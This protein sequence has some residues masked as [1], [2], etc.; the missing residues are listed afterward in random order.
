M[1]PWKSSILLGVLW[2][3]WHLPLFLGLS[4]T[5]SSLPH[6]ILILT[7]FSIVMTFL[8][9]AS[10]QSELVAVCGHAMFNTT[11]RWFTA[12]CGDAPL[13]ENLNPE[14]VIGLC[15]VIAGVLL[16]LFTKGRLA[17]AAADSEA[18]RADQSI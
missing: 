17:L 13:R 1:P 9:N 15:G 18:G 6:F 2:A 3:C 7:G 16:I 4:W 5:S 8:F 11:S 14:L 10:G 12:L